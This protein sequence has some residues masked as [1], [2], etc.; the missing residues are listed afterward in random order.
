MI[1]SMPMEKYRA[2]PGISISRLNL[3]HRSPAHYKQELDDPTPP[4]PAM[5]WGTMFHS[6]VFEPD[7]FKATYAVL[8]DKINR[9]TKEGKAAWVEWQA[10][11]E[12]KTPI[13]RPTMTELTAMRDSLLAHRKAG[14]ALS[15]GVAE[16]CLFWLSDANRCKGRPDY[17]KGLPDAPGEGVVVDLKTCLD[18]RP[19]VFGHQCWNLRYHAQAAFYCDGYEAHFGEKPKGFLIVAIEKAPPY[20]VN[21]FLADEAMVD[22]GRRE[23]QADLAIYAECLANDKWPAYPEVVQ[24]LV[25]PRWAEEVLS[26]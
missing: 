13:D 15:G 1:C 16:Q 9:S 12:G 6:F 26:G 8:E 14:N 23:Y 25:L 3:L 7:V 10:S 18:A 17:I 19:D 11:N 22:Q 4:T 5:I 21:V 2:A 20:A 24:A